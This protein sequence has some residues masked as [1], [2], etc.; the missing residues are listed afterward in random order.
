[1]ALLGV[2]LG[3]LLP[4]FTAKPKALEYVCGCKHSVGFHTNKTGRCSKVS[5]FWDVKCQCQGYDGPVPPQQYFG[6]LLS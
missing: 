6:E 4:T 2:I 1:M 3:R 5:G